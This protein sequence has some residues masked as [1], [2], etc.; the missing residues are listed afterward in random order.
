MFWNIVPDIAEAAS[1]CGE[2]KWCRGEVGGSVVRV[3]ELIGQL[4]EVKLRVG[5]SI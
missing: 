2:M 4:K 5:G 1:R 3:L